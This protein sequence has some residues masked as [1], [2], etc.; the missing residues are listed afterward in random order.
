MT[1]FAE[2]LCEPKPTEKHYL[3]GLFYFT[4][5]EKLGFNFDFYTML[6]RI[7]GK[8]HIETNVIIDD[9]YV[10][11]FVVLGAIVVEYD[12]NDGKYPKEQN[13]FRINEITQFFRDFH[14]SPNCVVPF[15]RVNKSFELEGIRAIFE[16]CI[17]FEA[18]YSPDSKRVIYQ[19]GKFLDN[20]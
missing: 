16:Q 4:T 6:C 11:E 3:C 12:N 18:I 9:K 2:V 15:V 20:E 19:S 17:L 14:Y 7:F 10:L 13:D 5:M 1:R 8:E